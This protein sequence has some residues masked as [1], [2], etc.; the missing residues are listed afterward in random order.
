MNDYNKF[1]DDLQNS[2]EDIEMSPNTEQN[3]NHHMVLDPLN[4]PSNYINL[5]EQNPQ[6]NQ[7]PINQEKK[8]QK[9][10][11]VNQDQNETNKNNYGQ[12]YLDNDNIIGLIP[13]DNDGEE[14]LDFYPELPNVE[15]N[16]S[17]T[18][19]QLTEVQASETTENNIEQTNVLHLEENTAEATQNNNN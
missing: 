6:N 19:Y 15:V 2:D 9:N 7:P 17:K 1:Y 3:P 11:N 8:E 13:D 10:D 5:S 18:S 4:E 16:K 14:K 12:N